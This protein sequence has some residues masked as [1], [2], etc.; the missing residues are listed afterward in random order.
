MART[1]DSGV[2]PLTIYAVTSLDA[3]DRAERYLRN[4]LFIGLPL[5]VALAAWLISRVVAR[6]LAPVDS[7]RAEVDPSRRPIFRPRPRQHE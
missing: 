5:Q 4:A 6:A 2:G 3:A 1:V 7:M